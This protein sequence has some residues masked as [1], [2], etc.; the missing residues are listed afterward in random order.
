MSRVKHLRA[1]ALAVTLVF[2]FS[3]V[4]F[5]AAP[6]YVY[7][8]SGS[9]M[10]KVDYGK[11]VNDAMNNDNTL[12]NAVKQY[13]GA[14]EETGAP[15]IVETDD[16]KVLDY[17]KALGAGKRFTDIVND[18]AYQATKPEAGKEL[19]VEN[20]Q[21]VIGD[22]Q[23]QVLEVVSVKAVSAKALEVTFNKAIENTGALSFSVQRGTSPVVLDVSWNN[24]KT[25]ATLSSSTN[26]VAGTYTIAVSGA[27][28]AEGK[29]SGSVTVDAQKV[30]KIEFTSNVIVKTGD[31]TGTIGYK[32]FDQY[33][34]DVTKETVAANIR[35]T[36]SQ[37]TATDDN[38]GIITFNK[39][40][41][42]AAGDS[43][44][45]T[46]IDPASGTTVSATFTVGAEATVQSLTLGEISLPGTNTRI[47]T[48]LNPAARIALTG[49][50][51]YGNVLSKL[52]D[53]DGKVTVVSS[54]DAV[55]ANLTDK[56]GG[57]VTTKDAAIT[58]DTSHLTTAK[59]VTITV[60]LNSTG[61][62]VTKTLEIV[63]PPAPATVSLTAPTGVIA[64]GD[65][66]YTVVIPLTVQD[67]F[68]T[69]L[70][71]D[72]IAA[73]KSAFTITSS[74]GSVIAST[75]L[76]IATTGANKGKLVNK[77]PI[78][79]AGTTTITVTVNATGKSDSVT[80]T[81][82]AARHVAQV[83]LPDTL[84]GNML[85]GA[86][87]TFGVKFKDQYGANFDATKNDENYKVNVTITK[88]SG[89]DNGLT[90]SPKTGVIM[91]ASGNV[92]DESKAYL[93]DAFTITAVSGKTGTYTLTVKLI[94]TSGETVSQASKTITVAA[95]TS[96]LSYSIKDIPVL[97][98]GAAGSSDP[99][100]EKVEVIA[101]D[102]SGNSYAI[103]PS[104][105]LTIT[106]DKSEV[107]VDNTNKKVY[108]NSTSSN[109]IKATITVVFN[110]KDDVKTLTKEVTVSGAE[111]AAQKVYIIDSQINGVSITLPS[112]A[113]E[114]ST[115]NAVYNNTSGSWS[116]SN[117]YAG[118]RD[119]FGR[120]TAAT[121]SSSGH[122]TVTC[123]V[124]MMNNINGTPSVTIDANGKVDIS[125][126]A[127]TDITKPG[128]FRVVVT[129]SNGK[130]G[131]F[132][133]QVQTP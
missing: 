3:S 128:S 67:Q 96:S 1:I 126:I 46:G 97:Y 4:A 35:W 44:V 115:V 110:T 69:T 94:N 51:Q 78:A 21:P 111:L 45:I 36:A 20:G 82:Q 26:L 133:V 29:N 98:K 81:V 41:A 64:D 117:V 100:S 6:K 62:T 130:V 125:G 121:N 70:T 53:F 72:E 33:G 13:V 113:S 122:N 16:Q 87:Q 59:S 86:T 37:G 106:S 112:G 47:Y 30:A 116:V 39:D 34:Q 43:F 119:Q 58:I 50:D 19:R 54:D 99:Y 12:Y 55:V 68:G 107:R 8:Q 118:V 105:I 90:L 56:D 63:T 89:D 103:N 77:D 9:D 102:T 57:A 83:S 123:T 31:N 73:N 91:D 40:T 108:G 129:T 5:A 88:V 80:L 60:I 32:V 124:T 2:L 71:A 38:A 22:I 84:V 52:G 132:T 74:N 49:Q 48:G 120:V 109:D 114:I 25:V 127:L 79:G 92:E 95:A 14:A 76:D 42:F 10:V 23:P 65:P 75:G 7:F 61:Q 17:Q 131:Y 101:T 11:A 27:D 24:A 85:Q 93:A 18:P 15:V 104:D 66:D 28:F